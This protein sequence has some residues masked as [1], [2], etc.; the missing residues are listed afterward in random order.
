[1]SVGGPDECELAAERVERGDIAAR[2]PRVAD[3]ADDRDRGTR[4]ATDRGADAA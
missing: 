4:R 3:V 2:N 1:M